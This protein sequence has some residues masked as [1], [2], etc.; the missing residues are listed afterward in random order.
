LIVIGFCASASSG[1]SAVPPVITFMR[2]S[3]GR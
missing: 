3:S 2:A 1:F